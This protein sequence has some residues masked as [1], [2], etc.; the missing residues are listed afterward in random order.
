MVNPPAAEEPSV[1][2]ELSLILTASPD[3]IDE[4]GHVSNIAYVRWVQ[5][6]AKAHSRAVGWD[7]AAYLRLGAVFVVRRHQ[8]DYLAPVLA[9]E[10]IRLTT[11]IR[12]WSAA[13]CV[14]VTQITNVDGPRV[15]ARA[16]TLWAFVAVETGRPRRIPPEILEAFA[17]PVEVQAG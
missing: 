2:P 1:S 17:R 8:V 11:W 16:E 9:G 12:S 14:R 5:E 7:H 15:V 6:V 4:L 13:T 10:A 3:D